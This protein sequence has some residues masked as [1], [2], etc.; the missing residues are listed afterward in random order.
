MWLKGIPVGVVASNASGVIYIEAARK[1]TEWMIH[2]V[3]SRLPVLFL[4]GSPGYMVGKA[5]EWAGIGKYGADMVRAASC[6][7]TPKITYVIGP[8]HGAANY[9]RCGRALNSNFAFTNMRGRT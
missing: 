9:G 7:N 4:Q 8:D 6:L 1:A 5:E 3:V 2:C